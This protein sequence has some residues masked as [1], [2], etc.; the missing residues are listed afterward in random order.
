M[1]MM[2]NVTYVELRH[3]FRRISSQFVDDLSTPGLAMTQNYHGKVSKAD[4]TS[5]HRVNKQRSTGPR[6]SCF[7]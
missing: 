2:T 3:I 6:C 7:Q 1:S 5:E 4:D